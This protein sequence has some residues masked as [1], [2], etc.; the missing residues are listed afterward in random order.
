MKSSKDY[1]SWQVFFVSWQCF[2]SPLS[3][4]NVRLTSG[5]DYSFT[6][7]LTKPSW[8]SDIAFRKYAPAGS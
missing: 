3:Q 2:T 7:F 1:I 8:S 5:N 6:I 4:E